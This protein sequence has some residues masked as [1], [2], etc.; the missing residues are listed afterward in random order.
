MASENAGGRSFGGPNTYIQRAGELTRL[1][2][3][4]SGLGDKAFLLADPFVLDQYGPTLK[5]SMEKAALAYQLERFNGECSQGEIDRVTA[6]VKFSGAGV[7]VGIGGGKTADTAK[8][9][10]IATGGRI[11]IVPTIASTDAPCSAIA[12]RYSDEGVYQEAH[13][14]GRN[15]D[16]VVVD[17]AVVVRAPVRFLVAG[18]GDALSTWFEA[19]SNLDSNSNNLVR[20]NMLPPAAGIAIARAC[21]DVLMRDALAA[22]LAAEKGALTSAVENIIE[23]NTLLSGLGFENCGVSA[24]H[25]IHDGLT[26]LDETHGFFHGEKVAFG[27]LCLLMLEGRPLAEISEMTAFCRA[28]GLPT[29][30]ADLNLANVSRADIERVAE[31]ALAEGSPTWKVAVPLSVAIVRDA[32]IATDAFT[33]SFNG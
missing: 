16:I 1:G 20:P 26:V 15:P 23:A 19:R 13:F 30:L 31:A 3:H 9:A 2:E 10:A 27:V 6:L 33:S 11:A 14:L 12:V 4:V 17:S 32:I 28:L 22:K 18:I 5:E 7:V 24:A 25:G 29:R 8:M 21:H